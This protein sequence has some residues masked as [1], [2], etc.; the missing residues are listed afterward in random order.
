MT[1]YTLID[2]LLNIVCDYL[3]IEDILKIKPKDYKKRITLYNKY[4]NKRLE[5]NRLVK[6]ESKY[7]L[8]YLIDEKLVNNPNNI[9]LE[10]I[11]INKTGIIEFL[12]INNP[13][14]REEFTEYCY[15]C[16]WNPEMFNYL[17]L[18]THIYNI[19]YIKNNTEWIVKYSKY[20]EDDLNRTIDLLQIMQTN[21]EF[22]IKCLNKYI[23]KHISKITN[24][25]FIKYI[26]CTLNIDNK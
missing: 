18:E 24:H 7:T 3:E 26:K 6:A 25:L 8:Q 5:I 17:K 11:M 23:L 15:K 14:K 4:F 2:D 10:C 20:S 12:I 22:I 9:I 16:C 19:I 13:D 1:D 21:V